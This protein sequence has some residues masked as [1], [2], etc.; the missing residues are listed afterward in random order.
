MIPNNSIPL[1]IDGKLIA[2]CEKIRNFG[3]RFIRTLT[4]KDHIS[5]ITAKVSCITV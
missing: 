4:W 5:V 2:Q 3:V 1:M